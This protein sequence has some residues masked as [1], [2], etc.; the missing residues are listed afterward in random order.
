MCDMCKYI[1]K[2]EKSKC[3][4]AKKAISIST[5]YGKKPICN[6]CGKPFIPES[7]EDKEGD[8]IR[9]SI[10]KNGFSLHYIL[11]TDND[12]KNWGEKLE[13]LVNY[14]RMDGSVDSVRFH[15]LVREII[16]SE[17]A[18]WELEH[19]NGDCYFKVSSR[20]SEKG[21]EIKIALE[22]TKSERKMT[23]K[24][25]EIVNKIEKIDT[26]GGGNGRRVV[27]QILE[28]IKKI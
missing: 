7:S 6:Q 26:S 16:Q 22:A 8:S 2:E 5:K 23:E 24:M 17:R 27:A 14:L 3:C 25:L 4:G 13:D 21:K 19:D 20:L 12:W 28:L 15:N 18:K 10:L 1:M 9:A 11:N